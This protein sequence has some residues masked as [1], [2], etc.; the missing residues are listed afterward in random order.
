MKINIYP[1][2]SP[3]YTITIDK[4]ISINRSATR[5]DYKINEKINHLIIHSGYVIIEDE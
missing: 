2:T 3:Q 4:L 1:L 5:I